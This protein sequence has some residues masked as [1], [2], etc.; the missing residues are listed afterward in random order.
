MGPYKGLLKQA[1][2]HLE[3]RKREKLEQANPEHELAARDERMYQQVAVEQPPNEGDPTSDDELENRPLWGQK[4]TKSQGPKG[5]H[6]KQGLQ[7][8]LP[9]PVLKSFLWQATNKADAST[10]STVGFPREQS[11]SP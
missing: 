5:P 4:A 9:N 2:G 6:H 1:D 11:D 7:A 8:K 10:N 3:A